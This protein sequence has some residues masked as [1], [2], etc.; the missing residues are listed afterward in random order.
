GIGFET[1][2]ITFAPDK[3]TLVIRLRQAGADDVYFTTRKQPELLRGDLGTGQLS[4]DGFAAPDKNKGPRPLADNG[5]RRLR[6]AETGGQRYLQVQDSHTGHEISR[7]VIKDYDA[8]A[9]ALTG[10]GAMAATADFEGRIVLWLVDKGAPLAG[11]PGKTAAVTSLGFTEDGL[12]EITIRR[13][14]AVIR[15]VLTGEQSAAVLRAFSQNPPLLLAPDQDL[16]L[17]RYAGH[18]ELRRAPS[19]ELVARVQGRPEQ[20]AMAGFSADGKLL[21]S[22][23]AG[24]G[25]HIFDA[26]DGRRMPELLNEYGDESIRVYSPDGLLG[27]DSV[28]NKRS[29]H[30]ELHVVNA[31]TD[32]LIRRLPLTTAENNIN[33]VVF[34]PDGR[35]LATASGN[36]RADSL[37]YVRLWDVASGREIRRF[38]GHTLS[39]RGL[40]FS[41][42]GARLLTGSL[43]RTARL[44]DTDSGR[45]LLRLGGH[46]EEITAVTFS[47]DGRYALT[48]G[49][50]GMNLFHDL[51]NGRELC[52]MISFANGDWITLTADGRFDTNNLEQTEGLQWVMPDAPLQTLPLEIFA[53][54]YYEPRL[55]ARLLAGGRLAPAPKIA[56]LNR[57]QPEVR[58][59]AVQS[60]APDV[61]NVTVEVNSVRGALYRAGRLIE[62]ESG[63]HDLRL[64]RDGQLVASA[65]DDPGA[66]R[67]EQGRATITFRDVRLPRRADM[68]QVEFSAYA[69]NDARVRSAIARHLYHVPAPLPD[70]RGRAYVMTIGVNASQQPQF[71]LRF[72]VND[73]R[74]MQEAL[75]ARLRDTGAFADIV[76]IPLWSD[77]E[78][79]DGR[80]VITSM[81]ATRQNLHTAL[82]LL[83]GAAVDAAAID[84][85]P[86]ADRLARA[87]PEDTLILTFAGHGYADAAGMFYLVLSDVG[88][89]PLEQVLAQCLSSDAL[90]AWLRDV[91]AGDITMI[92][93]AC[94]SAAAIEGPDFKPGPMG[95]RGLGQMAYDK[96]IRMLTAT[97]ADNVALEN[98]TL[99]HGLLS[100]ALVADGLDRRRAD[101]LPRDRM[102]TL[103]EWLRYGVAR[104]PRLFALT[105]AGGDPAAEQG[106]KH[107]LPR[108]MT[109]PVND[110]EGGRKLVPGRRRDKAAWA[111]T[112][113]EQT[114]QPALFDFARA[115][116]R[117]LILE[118]IRP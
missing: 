28:Y 10:D 60:V 1:D 108:V 105:R 31:Q 39:V 8:V 114:Q 92:V 107:E 63:A 90:G 100:Y 55:L 37:V 68:R 47:P 43:D 74:R 15:N 7:L 20:F 19:A 30:S 3:K 25:V 110:T 95:S 34:S 115:Q 91:D 94:Q 65:P 62:M 103:P 29:G 96:G 41:P 82:R 53:R 116:R 58:I 80:R 84:A 61:V 46:S 70:A 106:G 18:V 85:L 93:D 71:D 59:A 2:R 16:A 4:P 86:G 38:S 33:A 24:R 73:A 5:V 26:R 102:I 17:V 98:K 76:T 48:R 69:F 99:G 27:V 112:I 9:G 118:T 52:R 83:A 49:A 54:H 72:A 22:V 12:R 79:R 97:Q 81:H 66:L 117:A 88:D 45:E 113:R 111:D 14:L 44:W 36:A 11:W 78:T 50:D 42:D 23:D 64:F 21:I 56:E 77:S 6:F 67:L 101:F 57:L 40:T 75:A 89:G 35:W 51:T 13:E 32:K 104:V 87:R 109:L